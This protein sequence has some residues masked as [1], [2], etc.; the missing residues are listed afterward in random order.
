[1]SALIAIIIILIAIP[2][3]LLFWWLLKKFQF[4]RVEARK[5]LALIPTIALIPAIYY[6]L[7][8]TSIYAITYYPQAYFDPIAWQTNVEERYKMSQDIITS[9]V[10]I[11][12]SKKEVIDLLGQDYSEDEDRLSYYLGFAP[13]IHID[14]EFLLIYFDN[15]K[16][17]DV[18]QYSS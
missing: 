8:F 4:G 15:G 13:G 7:V 5:Y 3:Y 9:E 18:K 1:M 14:P 6:G 2:T 10:L 17:V 16:V 11:G 12:K